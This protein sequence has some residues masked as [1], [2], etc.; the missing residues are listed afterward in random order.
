MRAGSAWLGSGFG[1]GVGLGLGFGFGLGLANPNP[2]PKP[3]PHPN[4]QVGVHGRDEALEVVVEPEH[5]EVLDVRVRV[6]QLE[7]SRVA[8]RADLG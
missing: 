5:V 4:L 6:A 2:S 1:L 7:R 3:N 8:H